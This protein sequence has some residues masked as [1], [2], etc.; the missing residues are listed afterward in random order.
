[1]HGEGTERPLDLFFIG[2]LF[3]ERR[4]DYNQTLLRD[5]M[6]RTLEQYP[7]EEEHPCKCGE[8]YVEFVEE[9]CEWIK[10]NYYELKRC[11]WCIKCD[12]HW[13]IEEFLE[14]KHAIVVITQE[15]QVEE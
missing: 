3:F 7:K 6:A 10:R 11:Y 14:S 1:M 8:Q 12:C 15:P 9:E 2:G 4:I 13:Y 5:I